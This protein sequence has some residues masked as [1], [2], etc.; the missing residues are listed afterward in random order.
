MQQISVNKRII[1][2]TIGWGRGSTGDFV[3]ETEF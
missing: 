2:D 3:Q 1:L